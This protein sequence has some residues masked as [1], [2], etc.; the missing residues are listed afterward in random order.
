[1][2]RGYSFSVSLTK[3]DVLR[4]SRVLVLDP[5]IAPSV[6]ILD[7]IFDLFFNRGI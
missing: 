1:M 7:T 3:Y 6:F 5:Y 4:I 2:V